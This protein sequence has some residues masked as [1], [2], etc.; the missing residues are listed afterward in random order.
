M[1]GKDSGSNKLPTNQKGKKGSG[2]VSVDKNVPKF[3]KNK[4]SGFLKEITERGGQ[5]LEQLSRRKYHQ[6]DSQV[7][8]RQFNIFTFF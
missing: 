4:F 1:K 8:I 7:Y 3:D 6:L 2:Q 5:G